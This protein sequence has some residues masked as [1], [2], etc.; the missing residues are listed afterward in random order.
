VV[1]HGVS[2]VERRIGVGEVGARVRAAALG[3][4]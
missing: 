1:E 4:K 2:L 3:A